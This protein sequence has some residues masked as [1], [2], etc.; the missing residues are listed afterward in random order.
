M[1]RGIWLAVAASLLIAVTVGLWSVRVNRRSAH[2]QSSLLA[3]RDRLAD[4]QLQ[5]VAEH[6]ER[7]L[8]L[9]GSSGVRNYWNGTVT[10]QML[11]LPAARSVGGTVPPE[12]AAEDRRAQHTLAQIIPSER[13]RGRVLLEQVSLDLAAGRLKQADT[14]LAQVTKLLGETPDV[15]NAQA[16]R[17]LAEGK[18]PAVARA[19]QQLRRLVGWYPNYLPGWYNL[20][21]LL[22]QTG[23]NAESRRAWRE[24][25]KRETRTGFRRIARSHLSALPVD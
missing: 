25:L 24:Y 22:E 8:A 17:S 15:L 9:A 6:K 5:L 1:P 11:D 2:L 16:M 10:P 19:E 14:T 7:Y 4:A 20:A 13:N 12:A 18:A 23:R 3:M 21:M